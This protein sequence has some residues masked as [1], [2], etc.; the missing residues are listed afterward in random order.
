MLKVQRII[1]A[2]F[3]AYALFHLIYGLMNNSLS[4]LHLVVTT[5]I[6]MAFLVGFKIRSNPPQSNRAN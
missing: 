2:L 6:G 5:I 3:L 4:W 1:G